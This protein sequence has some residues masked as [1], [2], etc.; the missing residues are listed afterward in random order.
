MPN[1]LPDHLFVGDDLRLCGV[2][3]FGDFQ[4]GARIGGP[5]YLRMSAPEVEP[6]WPRAGYGDQE[7]FDDRLGLRLLLAGA[8][9]QVGYL[10]HSLRKG[11]T[12]EAAVV[13]RSLRE[14]RGSGADGERNRTGRPSAH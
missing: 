4:D 12:E 10:A 11:N 13:A 3:D 1:V 2:I 6:G 9:H 7:P 8:E 14:T 5:V